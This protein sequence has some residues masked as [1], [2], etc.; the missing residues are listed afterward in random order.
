MVEH[1]N[2]TAAPARIRSS[3]SAMRDFDHFYTSHRDEIGRALTYT[4]GDSSLGQEAVD[5]AMARAYQR[6]DTL[7][8]TANPAGWVFVTGRRWGL[9]WLRGRRRERK[10]EKFVAGDELARGDKGEYRPVEFADHL[11][12]MNAMERLTVDQRTVVACR[13]SLGMSVS[14]TAQALGIREGTVKSRLA[15]SIDRLRYLIEE[16]S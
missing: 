13:F 15:R 10:R 14:E 11:D 3:C 7:G 6:W 12:L 4:F 8:A 2:P 9:S 5:E 16:R 1:F